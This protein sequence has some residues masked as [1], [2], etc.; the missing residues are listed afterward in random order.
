MCKTSQSSITK[1]PSPVRCNKIFKFQSEDIF[2]HEK[3]CFYQM[4]TFHAD[5]KPQTNRIETM[6]LVADSMAA[7]I[8]SSLF[9]VKNRSIRS[10]KIW[11][12]ESGLNLVIRGF[13]CGSTT[14]WGEFTLNSFFKDQN[15][16]MKKVPVCELNYTYFHMLTKCYRTTLQKNWSDGACW[17][18][19]VKGW[20]WFPLE[21]CY[22]R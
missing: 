16:L 21:S 8:L 14:G 18:S 13:P 1:W 20:G 9:S 15:Y 22:N 7:K 11:L 5:F 17:G 10:K 3:L 4:T 12:A 2:L 6:A 19:I